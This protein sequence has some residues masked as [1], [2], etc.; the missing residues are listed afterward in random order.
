MNHPNERAAL[1]ITLTALALA[2]TACTAG[3]GTSAPTGKS[4]PETP[5]APPSDAALMPAEP[6]ERHECGQVSALQGI[7]YR[8]DWEHDQGLIDDVEYAS[9]VAAVED[10]WRYLPIGGTDV[11]PAIKVAQ[12]ALGAGGIG[13]E[14][15]EFQSAMED[16]ARACDASGSLIAIGALP[17][18]GG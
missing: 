3:P 16:V 2:L 10:G 15:T 18:Q 7:L 17:G 6:D 9:R 12:R 1:V 5:Q 8:S 14:N 11:T 13:H 4:A